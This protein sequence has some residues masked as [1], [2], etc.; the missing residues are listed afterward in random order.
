M[1]YMKMLDFQS[2]SSTDQLDHLYRKGVYIGKRKKKNGSI[3]LLYQLD[4]FYVEVVYK[5]YR[6]FIESLRLTES[7][8][9]LD[10]YLEQIEVHH[11][12]T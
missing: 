10:P 11:L 2:L 7:T 9:I 12:V 4:S 1:L 8:K 6:Y 5:K 3:V